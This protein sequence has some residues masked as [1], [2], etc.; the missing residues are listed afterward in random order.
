MIAF[1][2]DDEQALIVETLRQFA[3]QEIRPVARECE[4]TRTLPTGLLDRA[5][6]LGLVQNALP[7]RAG[8]GGERSAITGALI[9]EE[10]AWGDLAI[11]AA[12]LSPAL[13][14]FPIAEYGDDEQGALLAPFGADAFRPGALAWVE[15]RVDFDPNRP[16]ARAERDGEGYRLSGHKCFVPWASSLESALVL[17]MSDDGPA[18]FVIGARESGLEIEAERNMGLGALPTVELRFDALSLPA[19]ARIGGDR[20]SLPRLLAQSRVAQGAMAVGLAR[21]AFEVAR[22]YAKERQA[23]GAPIATKQAIAFELAQMAIEIDGAR[24]LVWEAAWHLDCEGDPTRP[25]ARAHEQCARTALDVADSAVQILGGH[26]Y[27]RDYLPE[28]H[29]RNA[30]AFSAFTGLALV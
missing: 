19:S 4:E 17:A 16:Q 6:T 8:G 30:R 22:D 11:A 24:L 14:A 15:P 26:G 3:E 23:F 21:A 13:T 18:L 10:L 25:A 2:P 12:I 29:L 1:E 7:E 20:F 9:A 28:L 27:I 5:H